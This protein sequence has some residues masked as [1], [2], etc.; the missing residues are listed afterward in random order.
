MKFPPHSKH[1]TFPQ[2]RPVG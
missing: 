2:K 1:I